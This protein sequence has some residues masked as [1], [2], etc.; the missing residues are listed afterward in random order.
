[1]KF[2]FYCSFFQIYNEKVYDL[3]QDPGEVSALDLHGDEDTGL[4]L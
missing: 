4:Y 2:T 3:L 1:M